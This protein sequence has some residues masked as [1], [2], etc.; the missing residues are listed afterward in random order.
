MFIATIIASTSAQ[1]HPAN[2]EARAG[3]PRTIWQSRFLHQISKQTTTEQQLILSLDRAF[4]HIILDDS[5]REVDVEMFSSRSSYREKR[6]LL[7]PRNYGD[8]WWSKMQVHFHAKNTITLI[9][10][11]GFIYLAYLIFFASGDGFPEIDID[12]KDIINYAVLAAEVGGHAVY[13][14]ANEK[15]LSIQQKGLT[16]EGKAE[17]LTQA[18][19]ISNFLILDTLKRFPHLNIITEEKD[20]TITETEA[21]PYRTDKYAAWLEVRN[22]LEKFPSHRYALGDVQ[23]YVD[24]LDAT[25]EYTEGLTQYV[26]VMTC[27]TVKDEPIFGAIY[28]PFFNET[29]VG[30]RDWGVMRVLHRDNDVPLVE[31]VVLKPEETRK[32][33]V[34][35][36]SHA[37]A[38]EELAKAA[39]GEGYTVEPAGGSGY[40]TLRVLNGTAEMYVHQTAIKKW[41]TCAGDALLRAVGGSMLDLE[42]EPL[43]YGAT[44]EILNKKG[45]IATAQMPYTYYQKLKPHVKL[46]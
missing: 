29:I 32:T 7:M 14:I 35:S 9:V 45:L 10:A 22:A 46:P 42:G 8:S 25:Q 20:S 21:E 30:L 6:G 3:S 17:L 15:A 2:E 38:V 27:I 37:G 40:K 39:F 1:P 28:R 16:D 18:D 12:V 26:T 11:V 4:T 34:V 43:K 23:I 13:S 31:K 19:L 24:P 44:S 5:D 33:I 36:R 41:D